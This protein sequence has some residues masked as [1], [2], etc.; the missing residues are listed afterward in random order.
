MITAK[1]IKKHTVVFNTNGGSPVSQ[2]YVLDKQ[3]L[4]APKTERE[5]FNFAGWSFNG[6]IWDFETDIVEEDITLTAIWEINYWIISFDTDGGNEIAPFIIKRG[7]KIPKPT[8]PAKDHSAFSA[9]YFNDEKWDFDEAP[10]GNMQLIAKWDLNYYTVNYDTNGANETLEAQKIP[11]YGYA[12]FLNVTKDGYKLVGWTYNGTDWDFENN[13][14]SY[15]ITLVAKWAKLY[16][17]KFD[18]SGGSIGDSSSL[19]SQSVAEAYKVTE[20]E[21]P[22]KLHFKFLGWYA[23]GVMWDFENDTVTES[24]TLVARWEECYSVKFNTNGG[25]GHYLDQQRSKDELVS[26]PAIAPT[27]TGYNFAGWY[28]GEI[29]WDFETMKP[30]QDIVLVA[31]WEIKMLTVTFD[32]NGAN[33]IPPQTV[34]YGGKIT[35]PTT[36]YISEFMEFNGWRTPDRQK[37]NFDTDIVTSD[38]TLKAF[39]IRYGFG[40]PGGVVGPPDTFN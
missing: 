4:T 33:E 24:I 9:W 3:K 6:E 5:F 11:A 35:I 26:M 40:A 14:V 22:T 36:P 1:W 8:T 17:V 29:L 16:T 37:W 34:P 15:D 32:S 2:T 7:E 13:A 25:E 30:T 31:K 19:S 20:P 21:E 23:D 39:W 27:R 18:L 28:L 38:I 12:S 10:S